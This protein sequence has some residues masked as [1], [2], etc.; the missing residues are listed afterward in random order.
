VD[1]KALAT[2]AA[3]NNEE[4]LKRKTL[5]HIAEYDRNA[6][7][8]LVQSIRMNIQ[9]IQKHPEPVDPVL[10]INLKEIERIVVESIDSHS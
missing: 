4:E 10:I 7:D 1:I 2:L 6:R 3:T 8:L 9:E 5:N